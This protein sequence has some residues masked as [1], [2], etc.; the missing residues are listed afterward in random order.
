M[1]TGWDNDS[2]ACRLQDAGRLI[3]PKTT[4]LSPPWLATG[5]MCRSGRY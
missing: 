3:D 4:M 1:Q 5:G 2:V